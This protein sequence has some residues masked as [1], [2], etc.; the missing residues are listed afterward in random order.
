MD[1]IGCTKPQWTRVTSLLSVTWGFDFFISLNKLL[2]KQS[3]RRKFGVT[4]L[5]CGMYCI[6]SLFVCKHRFY[7]MLSS[8][9]HWGRV[10]HIC[11]SA[12]TIIGSDNGLSP[13]RRQTIIWINVGVLLIRTLGTNFSELSSEIHIFS[14]RK[15]HLKMSSGKWRPFC[16]GLNELTA[17]N[18]NQVY[19]TRFL[20]SKPLTGLLPVWRWDS[21]QKVNSISLSAFELR[22]FIT[23]W[24]KYA[25]YILG[26][27]I[28]YALLCFSVVWHNIPHFIGNLLLWR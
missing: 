6:Y 9:T 7:V 10:T 13:D 25:Y 23:H 12:L 22:C 14:L 26:K 17:C 18:S 11:V 27:H 28:V 2:N 15:M 19:S 8:L 24:C 5:S 21:D 4:S 3:N 1:T 20:A 16:L